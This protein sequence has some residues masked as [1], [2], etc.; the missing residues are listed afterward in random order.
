MFAVKEVMWSEPELVWPFILRWGRHRTW[1][2]R[3]AVGCVLLEHLVE[4]H[5][6]EFFPRVRAA[7]RENWRFANTV[8]ICSDFGP[9]RQRRRLA[10]LKSDIRRWHRGSRP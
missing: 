1:D 3:A 8:S 6:D 7:A 4:W 9:L 2:L 10:R 5:G